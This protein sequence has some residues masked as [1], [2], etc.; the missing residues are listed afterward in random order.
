MKRRDAKVLAISVGLSAVVVAA[1]VYSFALDRRP[2]GPEAGNSSS[3][4]LT[5]TWGPSL[6]MVEAKNA[7]CRS[8]HVG[9]MGQ[10]LVLHGLWPQPS[11]EQYCGLPKQGADRRSVELPDDVRKTLQDL[12][13]DE[14]TMA[15]HEWYA[16]GTCSGVAAPEYFGIATSLATQVR[17]LLDPVFVNA[18]GDRLSP[19]AVRETFDAQFGGG[20]GQRVG[21]TCRDVNG[22]SIVYEV[23][24]SL[25][26]VIDLLADQKADNALPLGDALVKGPAIPPGC[27][28]GRV[29]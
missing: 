22:D 8:G 10:S 20:A 16:H 23:H 6:C 29:P 18:H 13:S 21:L 24:L 3:S 5:L 25:P 28:R 26:S 19:R 17:T 4:W 11:T 12:M 2:V 27:G 1:I 14:N 9:Q 15:A 7:G